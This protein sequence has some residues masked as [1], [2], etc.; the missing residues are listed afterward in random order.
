MS[1][2][3][4]QFSQKTN[5]KFN[6]T[7]MVPEVELFLFLFWGELKTPKRRIEINWPSTKL[8][9]WTVFRMLCG[10]CKPYT[11]IPRIIV[12]TTILF[13]RLWVQQVFK[14]DN[15]SREETI[16]GNTVTAFWMKNIFWTK[17]PKNWHCAATQSFAD[18]IYG[19]SIRWSAQI[20][21]GQETDLGKPL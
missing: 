18:V 4:L 6:F 3:Y 17:S 2:W 15:Y 1:F 14:G 7:T 9:L 12:A 8:S 5:K 13:W 11:V 20:H 19:W 21:C 10:S 16:R